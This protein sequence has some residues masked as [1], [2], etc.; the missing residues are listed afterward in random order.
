L[1]WGTLHY[2]IRAFVSNTKLIWDKKHSQLV[3]FIVVDFICDEFGENRE[4]HSRIPKSVRKF[5]LDF[6]HR[7]EKKF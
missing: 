3:K 5:G 7:N 6:P 1:G 2:G 4:E